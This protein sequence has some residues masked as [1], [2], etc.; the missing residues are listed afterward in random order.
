MKLKRKKIEP[1]PKINRRLFKF[2]SEAVRSRS[3]FVCEY[4][5]AT[6]G[7]TNTNGKPTKIDAHHLM[8]RDIHNC[9]LKFDIRNGIALCP[10]CHKFRP[11]DSFHLNPVVTMRWMNINHPERVDFVAAN[12]KVRIA[13]DNRA[14]LYA[15]EEYLKSK[16]PLD[17]DTLLK[18]DIEEAQK[19]EALKAEALLAKQPQGSLFDAKPSEPEVPAT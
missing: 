12:Y 17:I 4:C 13:L 9:P 3:G 11:D 1:I 15:I 18:L 8:N 6:R 19:K 7:T 5:G 14:I 2:W 16:Q 10:S